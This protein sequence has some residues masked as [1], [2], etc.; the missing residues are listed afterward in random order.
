MAVSCSITIHWK[1]WQ[2]NFSIHRIY[3][4]YQQLHIHFCSYR[5]GL[6]S[7]DPAGWFLLDVCAVFC[8]TNGWNP[9]F[10]WNRYVYDELHLLLA[11][12]AKYKTFLIVRFARQ[13]VPVHVLHQNRNNLTYFQFVKLLFVLMY[14]VFK[15]SK[16]LSSFRAEEGRFIAHLNLCFHFIHGKYSVNLGW[17]TCILRL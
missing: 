10:T 11:V 14:H 15:K 16:V 17:W 2:V 4:C 9:I 13:I 12:P 5:I 7:K 1:S 3:R 6:V 8:C